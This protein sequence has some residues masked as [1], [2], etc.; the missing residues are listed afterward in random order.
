MTV[1]CSA[2]SGGVQGGQWE[3]G[4]GCEARV[5]IKKL[6]L[7]LGLGLWLWLL[8]VSD[9]RD[10]GHVRHTKWRVR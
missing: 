10:G 7:G 9:K 4:K 5:R 6:G 8:Q 2:G 3:G 1:T